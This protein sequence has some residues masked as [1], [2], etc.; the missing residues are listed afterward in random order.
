MKYDY[1][2]TLGNQIAEQI[3][4]GQQGCNGGN[5]QTAVDFIAAFFC[6]LTLC[7]HDVEE[8][9]TNDSAQTECSCDHG[10]EQAVYAH[11]EAQHRGENTEAH[12]VAQ[13]VDLDTEGLFVV[14]AVLFASGNGS[15]TA[16]Q[17]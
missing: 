8:A 15:V 12:T 6:L 1:K 5:G 11:K 3:G 16:P 17:R 2:N 9:Q 10:A 14:G 7:F 13:G 4:E